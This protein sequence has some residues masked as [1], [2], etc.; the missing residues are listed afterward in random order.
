LTH[1]CDDWCRGFVNYLDLL[2]L[3]AANPKSETAKFF[4]GAGQ[5]SAT[6]KGTEVG[7]VSISAVPGTNMNEVVVTVTFTYVQQLP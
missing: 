5:C 1:A 4:A 6:N 7:E 3:T 2:S